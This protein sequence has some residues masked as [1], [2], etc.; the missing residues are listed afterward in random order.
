MQDKMLPKQTNDTHSETIKEP[1]LF[2]EENEASFIS[3]SLPSVSP[4]VLSSPVVGQS[5]VALSGIFSRMFSS[6][7]HFFAYHKTYTAFLLV[8]ISAVVFFSFFSTPK[9]DR[10]TFSVVT[11]AIKQYVKVSGQVEASKD[12]NLSFQTSGQ[13]SFVGVKIGDTVVQGKVLATL[14]AGDAQAVVL[15][16]EANVSSAQAVLSQL[17]Q[18]ARKEE[19]A[20]KEQAVTN[21]KST[22][23][24]SYNALP[25]T[26]QNVDATTADVVKNKFSSLFILNNS[27]YILSFSS[28]DQRLQSEIEQ[29][30]TNLENILASFQKQSGVISAI[31][32][33]KI[34][35]TT[36][37]SAYQAAIMTND[38]VN[39]VS[40][41]LLA[42]CSITNSNL[43]GYRTNLS[44]VKTTM[45][46]LFSDI[47]GKRSMLLSSKNAF[48]QASRDL[49]LTQAGTDPYKIKSQRALVAQAQAQVV[50]ARSGLTKTILL[51]PFSGVITAVN[52]SE[53]ET[54]SVGKTII[55][56]IAAEGFE[57]EAK[58]PEIDIAKVKVGAGVQVTLDAYGKDV[59]FPATITRINPSATME[60]SV[61]MYKVIV[62]FTG[63]DAR[64]KQGMTANVQV[65][66]E[67]KLQ[68][69]TVP[70]RFVKI[71]NGERGTVS[72]RG[73]AQ[74]ELRDVV[75]GIRGVD[76]LIEIR[77]GLVEGDVIVAPTTEVRGAEK[78]PN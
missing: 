54:V 27:K 72:L 56:M 52:L 16:A 44:L 39:A 49:D 6:G 48:N 9:T 26:I 73:S 25:D 21:A 19:V 37:E 78:Q 55:A 77:S 40:N 10:E 57:I 69:I 64:V 38:L 70:A 17:Q 66:T 58:V 62:T 14:S 5:H 31:S 18:G 67:S 8:M 75:L 1:L 68:V 51:A 71:I 45:T 2:L 33:T 12:A 29:K 4:S 63:S 3:S 11:G 7:I 34:I 28:C 23:D 32:S 74:E 22:L 35:D 76:G 65:L 50:S 15:Q 41:L 24:Q 46:A 42:S 53:G 43:D 61:P 59:M 13:V 60:G 20:L 30:R 36:F 47:T